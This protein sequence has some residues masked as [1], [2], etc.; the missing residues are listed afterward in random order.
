MVE[1]REVKVGEKVFKVRELL[2]IETDAIECDDIKEKQKKQFLTSVNLTEEEYSKL[3]HKELLSLRLV[4]NELNNPDSFLL[5][6][7]KHS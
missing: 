6:N 7:L 2:G 4:Y 1:T 3:T 5:E